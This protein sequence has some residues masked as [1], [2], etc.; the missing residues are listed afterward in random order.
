MEKGPFAKKFGPYSH[1][2]DSWLP[3]S[4]FNW[5]DRK[6]QWESIIREG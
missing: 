3:A 2:G 1:R 5:G 4:N 6:T